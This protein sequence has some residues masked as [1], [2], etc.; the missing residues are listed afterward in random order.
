MTSKILLTIG[1]TTLLTAATPAS[2]EQLAR[3]ISDARSETTKTAAQLAATVDSIAALSK[4]T[5]GDLRPAY[6]K[7]CTEVGNTEAAAT[8][9]RLRVQWMA[10][11]GR[12]YFDGWQKTVSDISNPSL[13]KKSQKRLDAVKKSYAKV[14][15]SL[16]AG[17]EEFKP[18]LSDL[19]D[20]QSALALDVTPGGVKAM[21]S[22]IKSARRHHSEVNE[23]IDDAL[24]EMD[25]MQKSLSPEAK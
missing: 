15:A 8:W 22:T 21:K 24:K 25:K 17:G 23:A 4:Q 19:R 10:S 20:I 3:S 2:Q 5:K 13:R 6:E 1:L 11:D 18:F 14:E 16:K 7:F 9:T 12:Q